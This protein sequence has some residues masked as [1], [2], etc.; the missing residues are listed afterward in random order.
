MHLHRSNS[1]F[2]FSCLLTLSLLMLCSCKETTP[3]VTSDGVPPSEGDALKVPGD[4]EAAVQLPEM[5]FATSPYKN[6]PFTC[7]PPDKSYLHQK[8]VLDTYYEEGWDYQIQFNFDE[9]TFQIS[10]TAGAE[11]HYPEKCASVYRWEGEGSGHLLSETTFE[12]TMDLGLQ[13][14]R[15]CEAV[16]DSHASEDTIKEIYQWW[17]LG[18]IVYRTEVEMKDEDTGVTNFKL[19]YKL[20]TCSC[21]S[22]AYQYSQ[23]ERDRFFQESVCP[24]CDPGAMSCGLSMED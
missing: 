14:T 13:L 12:G 19:G 24:P 6:D 3:T 10:H 15:G 7:L 22:N 23:E 18:K 2:C 4:Q 11:R 9:K 16:G 8:S 1:I 21:N 17:I 5:I 20:L